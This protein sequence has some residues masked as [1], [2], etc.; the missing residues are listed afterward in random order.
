MLAKVIG[1]I[2]ILQEKSKINFKFTSFIFIIIFTN[3]FIYTKII[4]K[5]DFQ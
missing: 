5:G 1:Y 2:E 4:I 3:A